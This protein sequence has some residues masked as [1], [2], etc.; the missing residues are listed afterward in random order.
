[1]ITCS[2]CWFF[3]WTQVYVAKF[4]FNT[5]ESVHN[6]NGREI[7]T[8][9]CDIL[10]KHWLTNKWFIAARN[11]TVREISSPLNKSI[12]A[13]I[14]FCGCFCLFVYGF[15]LL[16]SFNIFFCLY[17]RFCKFNVLFK[18]IIALNS[19]VFKFGNLLAHL[20]STWRHLS[21]ANIDDSCFCF[22]F[23]HTHLSFVSQ[24]LNSRCLTFEN[25]FSHFQTMSKRSFL[26]VPAKHAYDL[27]IASR[28][29]S[30]VQ[31]CLSLTPETQQSVK[32]G[33][34]ELNRQ[35]RN[36]FLHDECGKSV[37]SI[38]NMQK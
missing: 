17:N 1:M 27:D 2:V 26:V 5:R 6:K 38:E 15:C 23:P 19:D 3:Y 11:I 7:S 37:S 20:K 31:T 24:F 10:M 22:P 12:A 14:S 28:I 13:R 35:R 16:E 36:A 32:E 25:H 18:L 21:V 4:A 33:L 29:N 34:D 8:R 30:Y 9:L